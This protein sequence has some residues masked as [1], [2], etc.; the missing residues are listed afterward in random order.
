MGEARCGGLLFCH[1]LALLWT[2]H[3]LTPD[4]CIFKMLNPHKN[5]GLGTVCVWKK[6][7]TYQ[8]FCYSQQFSGER[9]ALR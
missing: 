2:A 7:D 6:P 3:D 4:S 8:L 1:D 9:E 5:E